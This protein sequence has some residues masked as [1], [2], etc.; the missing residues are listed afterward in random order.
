MRSAPADG[1]APACVAITKVVAMRP[2]RLTIQEI[3][4]PGSV[5]T[6]ENAL[7]LVPGVI[8]VHADPA[9]HSVV[10]EAGDSVEI[11]ELIAAVQK[12][13]YIATLVG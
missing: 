5:E 11:D 12:A 3:V 2:I 1:V 13:G 6:V 8:S 10:V 7:R 9:A 4:S